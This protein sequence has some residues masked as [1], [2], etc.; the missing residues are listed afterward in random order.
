MCSLRGED[1][2]LL[3]LWQ[4][5]GQFLKSQCRGA[6]VYVLS[7]NDW[8]THA[9]H[10]VPDRKWEMQPDKQWRGKLTGRRNEKIFGSQERKLLHYHVQ[11]RRAQGDPLSVIP[12]SSLSPKS[13]TL[14]K[15]SLSSLQSWGN[16]TVVLSKEKIV[17][18]SRESLFVCEVRKNCGR[19]LS[20][21]FENVG[22]HLAHFFTYW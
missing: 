9:M 20:G 18:L 2:R 10:M 21:A 11:F 12:F 8:L 13:S 7:E 6:D 19:I 4:G 5:F 1:E 3:T 14:W 17:R 22:A 15:H 16:E